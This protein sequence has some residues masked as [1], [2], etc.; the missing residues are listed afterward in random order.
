MAISP[1][2]L[3]ER[4][5]E[6]I[7]NQGNLDL[8]DEL[9]SPDIVREVLPMAPI[10]GRGA[11]RQYVQEIRTAYPDLHIEIEQILVDGNRTATS[12]VLTGTHEGQSP[13]VP[14]PPTGK[15]IRLRG[16]VIGLSENGKSVRE[17]AYQDTLGLMQQLGVIPGPSRA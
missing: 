9:Y 15:K 5:I 16:A 6:E 11:M 14:I 3:V 10:V 8:I 13:S 12:F 4:V 17:V 2:Q 7:Y 1:K